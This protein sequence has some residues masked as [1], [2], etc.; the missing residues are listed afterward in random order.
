MTSHRTTLLLTSALLCFAGTASAQATPDNG[1]YVGIGFGPSSSYKVYGGLATTSAIPWEVQLN[2]NG[3]RSREA[4]FVAASAVGRARLG[5]SFIGFG[6]L[7][8]YAG[9]WKKRENGVVVDD[10]SSV[11]PGVG[12]GVEFQS[13]DSRLSFRAEVEG[14]GFTGSKMFTLSAQFRM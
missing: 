5:Q 1:P 4:N 6:K 14:A 11:R 9:E 7:G 8:L 13:G 10:G 12:A 2:R 3:S